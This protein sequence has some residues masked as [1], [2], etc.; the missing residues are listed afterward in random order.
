MGARVI[1]IHGAW[2][3]SW[4][5]DKMLPLMRTAGFDPVPVDLPGNGSDDT[6]LED[7][8]LDLYADFVGRVIGG[9]PVVLAG[10]SGGGAVAS[11]A[12]ER[13]AERVR[14]IV[15]IA[16]MMLP[17]GTTFA[18]ILKEIDWQGP[19]ETGIAPYLRWSGDAT[20]STVSTEG[21]LACFLQDVP[22]DEA[23]VAAG[24]LTPQAEAGR[25]L[26]PVTTP[27][28]F[29]RIPRL[30]V[31]ALDDRSVVLKAQRHM[32]ARVPGAERISL[33]TGHAPHVSAPEALCAA[34]AP[35]IERVSN[36]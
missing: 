21:A 7:V 24:K 12:A 1:L 18:E 20:V 28:R 30:Y 3:G 2:Q 35:F 17:G 5:W 9:G 11:A 10:H 6:P 8:D 31:E 27:E 29:G 33:P 19:P 14:G 13:F 25:H 32:Q 23:R 34:I 16:G 22:E 15:Y 4:V 26:A 36:S